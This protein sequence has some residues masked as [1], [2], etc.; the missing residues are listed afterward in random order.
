[1]WRIAEALG[2]HLQTMRE[3]LHAFSEFRGDGLGR[4]PDADRRPR[5]TATAALCSPASTRLHQAK[6]R[7]R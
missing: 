5:Q 7:L 1:M 6:Q 2:Y 4:T 3:Q